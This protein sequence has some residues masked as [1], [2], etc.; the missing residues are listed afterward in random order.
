MKQR[1][2]INQSVLTTCIM[3]TTE[4][5]IKSKYDIG[6]MNRPSNEPCLYHISDIAWF[7]EW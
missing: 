7:T 5:L 1:M 4:Y 2:Y 3:I 6:N